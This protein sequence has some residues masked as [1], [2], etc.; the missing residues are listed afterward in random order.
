MR[1]QKTRAKEESRIQGES[2]R[3]GRLGREQLNVYLAIAVGQACFTPVW[4]SQQPL[5]GQWLHR[6]IDAEREHWKAELLGKGSDSLSYTVVTGREMKKQLAAVRAALR[7]H[8]T[9]QALGLSLNDQMKPSK[10][11]R[12]ALPCSCRTQEL[13]GLLPLGEHSTSELGLSSPPL[14]EEPFPGILQEA[15]C[16]CYQRLLCSSWSQPPRVQAHVC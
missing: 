1:S 2:S 9:A 10:T 12:T 5:G 8:L 15:H 16:H 3:A 6:C 11:R 13:E 7:E 14:W 4:F